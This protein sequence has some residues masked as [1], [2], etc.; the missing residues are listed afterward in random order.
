MLEFFSTYAMFFL[1]AITVVVAI[2]VIF[3]GLGLIASRNKHKSREKMTIRNLNEKFE[4]MK[5]AINAEVLN[6]KEF[7]EWQKEEKHNQKGKGKQ[8]KQEEKKRIFVLNFEGD[9]QASTVNNLREAVTSVLSVAKKTDEV[10]IKIDS[11]G[12]IINGYGLA[13]SQ[14]QRIRDRKIPL[15]AA[16]DK[17]AA[18]GGY[19]MACVA[20]KIL[21][22]PF[23][24]LG[25]IGVVAEIPNFNR[26]L[27]KHDIVY[28][29]ITSNEYKRTLSM[30]GENTPKGRK[31]MQED[32]EEAH[33]LFEKFI[34]M[35][36]PK[37]NI[38]KVATGEHW[39]GT[40]AL[41]LKLIDTVQT[42]DDYL[43]ELSE[44]AKIYEVD[45]VIKKPLAERVGLAA[46]K[47]ISN[48]MCF[49]SK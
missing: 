43:L 23:A 25:S 13:A 7:K 39:Y 11:P 12:G 44:K 3:G 6:K 38:D 48:L 2:L 49:I 19:L 21:A 31:K 30:F 1:K 41:E 33:Q 24:I 32:V 22:A 40:R 47:A 45:Y 14:L 26:L 35:H 10:V 34:S 16:V 18:S 17:V 9:M 4:E 29:Q 28:E 20:D 37:V 27:K 15:T 46:Q 42:S 8:K 36:R 5:F